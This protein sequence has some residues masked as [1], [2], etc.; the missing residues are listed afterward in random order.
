MRRSVLLI[1]LLWLW[2]GMALAAPFPTTDPSQA[3][4]CR[5]DIHVRLTSKLK[6]DAL[7]AVREMGIFEAVNKSKSAI[8][9]AGWRQ[10]NR[11]F[12]ED[13]ES[14]LEA[15]SELTGWREVLS[16]WIEDSSAPP[17]KLVLTPGSKALFHASLHT[18]LS[19]EI[20]PIDQIRLRL[21]L[22]D[23]TCAFSE[24]FANP[25]HKN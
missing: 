20:K 19:P 3:E 1:P 17:D 6:E 10:D 9:V 24:P 2:A 11:F 8:S 7:G 21:K 18:A 4:N 22:S 16:W 23:G 13:P 15:G 5:S 14:R 12:I 25:Y